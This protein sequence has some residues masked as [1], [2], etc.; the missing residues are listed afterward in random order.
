MEKSRS[1]EEPSSTIDRSDEGFDVS[2]PEVNATGR[3]RSSAAEENV[4]SFAN[5]FFD[6]DLPAI[7][8]FDGSS[9]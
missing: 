9:T 1:L 5:D 8:S 6:L 3:E 4:I 2:A 7:L